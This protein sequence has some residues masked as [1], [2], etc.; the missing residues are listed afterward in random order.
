MIGVN[1]PRTACPGIEGA[2]STE[3]ALE[4]VWVR[5]LVDAPQ[6]GLVAQA[7]ADERLALVG[8]G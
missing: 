3:S 8:S 6:Q 7:A 2:A 5:L 1:G 4:R